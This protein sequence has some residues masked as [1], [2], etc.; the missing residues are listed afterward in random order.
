[1]RGRK[2]ARAHRRWGAG[3]FMDSW[4]IQNFTRRT[5][6]RRSVSL[7]G[8]RQQTHAKSLCERCDGHCIHQGHRCRRC[9]YWCCNRYGR[10]DAAHVGSAAAATVGLTGYGVS[11]TLFVL[12]LRDLGTARTGAYFS[13]A[14]FFGAAIALVVQ[15]EPMSAP[16][17][18][19]AGL[20]AWGVWLHLS[21]VHEHLHLHKRLEHSHSHVHD[22]HHQHRHE[23]NWDGTEPHTH[24]HVHAPL[25]HAHPH[26]PDIHHRHE[27]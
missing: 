20:M 24:L 16:L 9:E 22:A 15:H 23:S 14:P 3:A 18:I 26:Y 10:R 8:N 6:N 17:M 2:S 4:R 11:L 7:L 1:M 21:E 19:A 13:V 12:A 5:T 27:H 25:R